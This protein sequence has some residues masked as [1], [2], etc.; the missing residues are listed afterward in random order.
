MKKKFLIVGMFFTLLFLNNTSIY[1]ET[2][3]EY[4]HDGNVKGRKKNTRKL[5][6]ITP[7]LLG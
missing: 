4:V 3:E 7:K 6:L 5:S 1:A 2:A